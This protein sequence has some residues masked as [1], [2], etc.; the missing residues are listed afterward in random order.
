MAKN[1]PE[2]KLACPKCG[3]KAIYFRKDGSV[4]C[5]RCGYESEK[6]EVKG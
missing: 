3:K 4:R 5:N 2:E 6:K 1:E